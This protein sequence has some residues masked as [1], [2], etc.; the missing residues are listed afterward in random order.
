[1]SHRGRGLSIF[2]LHSAINDVQEHRKTNLL[3]L[4]RNQ[5]KIIFQIA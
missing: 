1:M 4:L 5:A 3:A 2:L